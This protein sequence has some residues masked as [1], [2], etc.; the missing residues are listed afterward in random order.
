[1]LF[2]LALARPAIS[3]SGVGSEKAPREDDQMSKAISMVDGVV[4]LSARKYEDHDDSLASA[5]ADVA[6]A[7]GLEAWEL[8]AK[9]TDSNR[10]SITVTKTSR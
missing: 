10:D 4:E 8:E 5:L 7:T 9:W 3:M 1:M 6:A 2:P